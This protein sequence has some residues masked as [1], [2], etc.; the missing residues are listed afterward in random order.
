MA[1]TVGEL[2]ILL[3]AKNEMSKV[4]QA[5]QGDMAQAQASG[6]NLGKVLGTAL[7][8]G[9]ALAVGATVA[10]GKALYDAGQA[11]AAE[12][13]GIAQLGAAVRATGA[14][15][16]AASA[17]IETYLA[18]ELR[19]T[20]LDDGAGREAISR[21]VTITGDY[22]KALDL[23]GLAQDLA[24][25]KGIDLS[26]AAEIVGRVSA[27]NTG[28]LSRYGI[29]L[30]EGA[31]ATEALAQ[32]QKQFAGQAEAYGNTYA[33]AQQKMDVALGN[34]K[35]TVGTLVL[36]AM[37]S[38]ANLMA[39]FASR[40]IP[41]VEQA[42]ERL[43]PLFSAAFEVVQTTVIPIIEKAV[44]W[45]GSDLP[46]AMGQAKDSTNILVVWVRE[47]FPLIQQTIKTVM[48][49]IETL[50]KAVW[51]VLSTV[52]ETT[53]KVMKTV[54]ETYI[55]NV[56]SIIRAV[57]L[58]INGDWSGAWDEIKGVLSRTWEAMKHIIATA[59]DFLLG[60][61]GTS[62]ENI[63][64][65]FTNIDWGA[66]GRGIIDGIGGGIM[67]AAGNLANAAADAARRALDAAKS[68]LGIRSPSKVAAE[69]IGKPFVEGIT[70]GINSAAPDLMGTVADMTRDMADVAANLT[71]IGGYQQQTGLGAVV[72]AFIADLRTAGKKLV[73]WFKLWKDQTFENVAMSGEASGLLGDM[74]GPVKQWVD[75]VTAMASYQKAADIGEATASLIADARIAGKQLVAFFKLWHDQTFANV[76]MGGVAS[77]ALSKLFAPIKGIID[78]VVAIAT[79]QKAANIGKATADLIADA[80]IAGKALVTYFLIWTENTYAN[81]EQATQAAVAMAG[82]FAPAT[83]LV[84]GVVAIATYQSALNLGQTVSDLIADAREAGKA[85]VT[86]FKLWTD[87]TFGNVDMA[88]SAAKAMSGLFDAIK[89]LAGNLV[90]ITE[91]PEIQPAALVASM[92]VL[93]SFADAFSLAVAYFANSVAATVAGLNALIGKAM[94]DEGK[95]QALVDALTRT[96]AM[97]QRAATLQGQ[98][99]AAMPGA[100][101][102]GGSVALPPSG[103]V[104]SP[105]STKTSNY[106][107]YVTTTQPA[108]N[109]VS[110]FRMLE[111]MA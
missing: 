71:S 86:Y 22:T 15:W 60:L 78:S 34:L 35:E 53:W 61:V 99:R 4:L 55:G 63:K 79:Y 7:A 23:M 98:I 58:I 64:A 110:S 1:I 89:E 10:V 17:A 30:A 2:A 31:T 46:K 100:G 109:V 95:I 77:E 32:M 84:D 87:N 92:A 38:L 52:L 57:M 5:V 106:N 26:S 43:R 81:V 27:G 90:D 36:P 66:L 39:D 50:W 94:P 82:L 103:G 101:A 13:V 14:D 96:L 67:N 107:L 54:V 76:E 42:I 33:G 9:A 88:T 104:I 24:A 29:V 47:N 16:G 11:A 48:D 44:A 25:A 28:I 72:D 108:V 73:D 75:G 56:L 80:R 85:L 12:E 18:A 91:I 105:A 21:L 37:T 83:T 74:F 51:P 97:L 3:T 41:W 111:A 49:A 102:T 93:T 69:E 20:A 62:L 65:K 6:M 19:R 68:F 40:A 59:L 8:G 70:V 45:I